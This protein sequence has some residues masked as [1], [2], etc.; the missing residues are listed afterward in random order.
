MTNKEK[1]AALVAKIKSR[2]GKNQYTQSS[3]R[4]Q[5]S[6]GYSD[7]SS[8]QQWVYEQVLDVNIGDN[9]EAQ[10]LSKKLTTI[11]A[12][13]SGGVR[14][15]ISFSLVICCI[16]GELI[17]IAR[18]PVTWGMWKCMWGTASFPATAPASDR[19]ART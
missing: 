5:V 14:T 8:L 7:C 18:P 19:P 9:T 16:S 6:S 3:R 2:E 4:D 1:R 10:M 13:I 12:G 15:R 11:D 17:R